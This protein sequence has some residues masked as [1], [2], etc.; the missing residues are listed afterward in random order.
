MTTF[1]KPFPMPEAGKTCKQTQREQEQYFKDEEQFYNEMFGVAK[2][3][4]KPDTRT[5][6]DKTV[7][8]FSCLFFVVMIFSVLKLF[9]VIHW[10]W[11]AVLLSAIWFP[12]LLMVTLYILMGLS[13]I[14][15]R[16]MIILEKY[17]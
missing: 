6:G 8:F 14:Y 16:I 13:R 15:W 12:A 4:K 7:D 5:F 9:G 1:N 11:T 3:E 2:K 17:I 10:S